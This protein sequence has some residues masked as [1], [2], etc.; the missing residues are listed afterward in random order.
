[1][2]KDVESQFPGHSGIV[3]AGLS[4]REESGQINGRNYCEISQ[5][6]GDEVDR[7]SRKKQN[8]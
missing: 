4:L 1:M 2:K 8:H 3:G 5:N 7:G 6:V